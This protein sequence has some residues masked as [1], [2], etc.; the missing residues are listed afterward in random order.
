MPNIIQ[1]V[2]K[3]NSQIFNYYVRAQFDIVQY[4]IVLNSKKTD[5]PAFIDIETN[6]NIFKMFLH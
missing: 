3:V 2:V 1:F 6:F 5:N 4:I